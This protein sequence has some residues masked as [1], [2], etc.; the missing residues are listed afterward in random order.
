MALE[1]IAP[2]CGEAGLQV[3]AGGD[4]LDRPA[5]VGLLGLPGRREGT[6]EH[7]PLALLAGDLRP[8]V[9]VRGVRQILPSIVVL[10]IVR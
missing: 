6:D 10:P 8:V 1:R 4:A 5:A 7:D 2:R 3:L 9:G